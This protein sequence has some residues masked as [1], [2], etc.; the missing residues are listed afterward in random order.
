M[1][2][3]RSL[4]EGIKK[5]ELDR[6]LESQFVYQADKAVI[7][8]KDPVSKNDPITKSEAS[9]LP[10]SRS[11]LTSKIRSDYV[12][13]LKRAS[14]ERQLAGIR[15]HQLQEIIEEALESWLKERGYLS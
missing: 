1:T 4:A 12:Q 10:P 7:S 3:R 11:Q 13:A 14:L 2:D 8:T 9:L 15:P 6:S 5:P